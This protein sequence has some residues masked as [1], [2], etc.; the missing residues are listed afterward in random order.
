MNNRELILLCELIS[1]EFENDLSQEQFDTLNNMLKDKDYA[2]KY[3]E[4]ISMFSELSSQSRADLF[5]DKVSEPGSTDAGELKVA[6]LLN[7]IVDIEDN[8]PAIEVELEQEQ[9]VPVIAKNDGKTKQK[10]KF[11]KIFDR[12]VYLAAVFMVIFIVYAEVFSPQY[13]IQVATVEDMVNVSWAKGSEQLN[14]TDR[15]LTNQ[16]PYKID[17]GIINIRFDQGV[18]VLVEGPAEFVVEK[19]GLDLTYGRVYSY[20][21]Q[22]G[23]GFMVDTPNSRFVDLGTEFG[24]V[25]DKDASAELHVLKGQ[26]QYF[27][28][29][30]GA[31]KATKILTQ[32][33][34]R[35]FNSLTG[36]VTTIPVASEEFARH[37]NS[38]TGLIWRGQKSIDLVKIAAGKN[39]S[40]K[41]GDAAGISPSDGKYVPAKFNKRANS[42][43]KYH[44][45]E[46]SIFVDGVFIPD[47]GNG[48]VVISSA[49]DTF[50]CPD[51]SGGFTQNICMF[52]SGIVREKSK[53][54]PVI[55][56]GVNIE[57]NPESIMAFHSNCGI[58]FDLKAFS[59]S[60]GGRPLAKFKAKGGITEF[61]A[62]LSG[63][64]ADVDLWILVDGKPRY[65]KELL[66][67]KDGVLDIDFDL[68]SSD[69]FLTVIV[70]DG[71]RD[72]DNSKV[73]P[74]AN[75]F[76]FLVNPEIVLGSK[77]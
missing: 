75:D 29:L 11:Y 1:A 61:V 57:D 7:K 67:V 14:K 53:I 68:N 55:F 62:G 35:R 38:N 32:N 69:R 8:A 64:A 47:G 41:I 71:L 77:D 58:T 36:E 31:P 25:V 76:F 34:A 19:N 18:D 45:V 73:N 21:T 51:T 52:R 2:R 30:S 44:K 39:D 5:L 15:L 60:M 24:V 16:F 46:E 43:N 49:G 65:V 50:A 28:G 59:N 27:S 54:S 26:V 56:N 10:S 40:W 4:I 3:V 37:V 33:S 12:I 63:R 23:R 74:W 22:T 9:I 48:E 72:T 20:V 42:D 13:T 6:E 17:H 70:T 66:M